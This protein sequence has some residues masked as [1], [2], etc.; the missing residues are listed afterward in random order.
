MAGQVFPFLLIC[1]V[2]LAVA[3]GMSRSARNSAISKTNVSNAADAC[4][5]TAGSYWAGGFNDLVEK[6]LEMNAYYD[7]YAGYYKAL[8]TLA[9]GVDGNGGYLDKA[10]LNTLDAHLSTQWASNALTDGGS[11]CANLVSDKSNAES[12]YYWAKYYA[13]ESARYFG[14]IWVLARY[15]QNLTDNFKYNQAQAYCNARSSMEDSIENAKLKGTHYAFVNSGTASRSPSGDAFNLFLGTNKYNESPSFGNTTSELTYDWQ[16]P[17]KCGTSKGGTTVTFTQPKIKAQKVQHTISPYPV[18]TDFD[19]DENVQNF[20]GVGENGEGRLLVVNDDIFNL[21]SSRALATAMVNIYF[22]LGDF[23]NRLS[24]N[25]S[26]E[27]CINNGCCPDATVTDCVTAFATCL[28]NTRRAPPS[29]VN[30]FTLIKALNAIHNS[31]SKNSLSVYGLRMAAKDILDNVWTIDT[32]NF[33]LSDSCNDVQGLA[34][35]AP[36]DSQVDI[37]KSLIIVGLG[38]EPELDP[39]LWQTECTVTAFY[40][41]IYNKR[42]D[43]CGSSSATSSSTSEFHGD[44]DIGYGTNNKAEYE[45]TMIKAS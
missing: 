5:I 38:D 13:L 20:A 34:D 3:V 33:S 40:T 30:L 37:T 15:M 10:Y 29:G 6:N 28:S 42:K 24:G 1:I 9:Y 2:A 35:N 32:G 12:H 21:Y 41:N 26:I 22:N 4:S 44:G 45:T 23:D 18:L 7:Q 31:S 39:S 43:T 27:F 19:V 36:A 14:A 17:S 11:D 8:H 16:W 25:D